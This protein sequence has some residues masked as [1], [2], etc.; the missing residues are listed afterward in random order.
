MKKADHIF[1][2]NCAPGEN[3]SAFCIP[4][5]AFPPG[6]TLIELVVVILIIG[7]L[8]VLTVEKI[9]S[10]APIRDRL[11][12]DELKVNLRYIRNLAVTRECTTLVTFDTAANSYSV[13]IYDTNG[14]TCAAAADPVT[15]SPWMVDVGKRFPGVILSAVSNIP[16]DQ[17]YFYFSGTNVIPCYNTN[18]PL[19]GDGSIVFESGLA[20]TIAR[21]TG[22]VGAD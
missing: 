16:G 13:F 10:L 19:A 4:H 7:I 1:L 18:T 5:S 12:A 20:V 6:F 15:Q 9:I 21:E 17:L 22:Y 14:S 8:A 11:A 3:S 2:G